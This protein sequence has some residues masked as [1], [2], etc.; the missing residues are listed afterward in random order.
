MKHILF[1]LFILF[2]TLM[3]A[4]NQH[5]LSEW[6]KVHALMEGGLP[7]S[8]E[9]MILEIYA[10]AKANGNDIQ[11]MKAEI[12]LMTSGFQ[13]D[14]NAFKQAIKQAETKSESAKFPESAIWKSIAAQL[15]WSYYEQNRWQILGRTSVDPS[16][17]MP[18]FETWDAT[19][20]SEKATSLYLSSISRE[21]DLQTITIEPYQDLLTPSIH[22]EKLR[23]TL[24][25]LLAF[26]AIHFFENEEKDVS[27]P[28]FAFTQN[29]KAA[30]SDVQTFTKHHFQTNDSASL[31]W[32]TIQLYRRILSFH[33]KDNS[34]DALLDANLARLQFVYNKSTIPTKKKLYMAALA[35]VVSQYNHHPL[36]ALASYRLIMIDYDEDNLNNP[37]QTSSSHSINYKSVKQRLDSIVKQF[38]NS[39]GGVLAKN[40]LQNIVFK[41][42]DLSTEKVVLPDEPSK[43]L[44]QYRN[45]EK[46]S[47]R[48][49]KLVHSNYRFLD[50]FNSYENNLTSS[51]LALPTLKTWEEVLPSSNDFATH[52]T[53][54][55]VAALPVG[56]YAVIVSAKDGFSLTDNIVSYAVFQVSQL[57]VL[58]MDNKG[59]VLDRKLGKPFVKADIDFFRQR[60]NDNIRDNELIFSTSVQSQSEGMF[61]FPQA[62]NGILS[63]RIRKGSDSLWFFDSPNYWN[64][65]AQ[66]Q[67]SQTRTFLFTDRAIYR[68]G[69]T[70]YFKGII[71]KSNKGGRQNQVVPKQ[72]TTIRFDDVNGQKIASMD[73]T[74]NEFGS[75]SG[76][77]V[78]P[79]NRLTGNMRIA[80]ENGSVD[81]SVEEYKRPKFKVDFDSIHSSY[82]IGENISVVGNTLAYAGNAV[83]NATVHYR[84]VRQAR[85]PFW[86]YCY[87]FGFP[88]SPE[89]E[90]A[91]GTLKTEN[92]GKFRIEFP[93]LADESV[94]SASLPIFSYEISAD[95]TDINGETRSGSTIVNAGYH[96]LQIHIQAPDKANPDQLDTIKVLT[97]NL[98]DQFVSTAIQLRILR[99]KSPNG[100]LRN[101]LWPAPDQFLMDSVSF[102]NFFPHDPYRNEDDAKTWAVENSVFDQSFNSSAEGIVLIP[103]NIWKNSGW[104]VIEVTLKDKSGK[105]LVEKK[106]VQVFKNDSQTLPTDALIA[107][108]SDKEILPGNQSKVSLFTGCTDQH[109]IQFVK[110]WDSKT[111]SSLKLN[112]SKPVQIKMDVNE[113]DR[114]GIYVSYVAVYENRMYQQGAFISVPWSNKDLSISWET[115]RDKLLPGSKEQWTMTIRGDQKEKVSAE[116]VATLYDASLDAF[117][118]LKWNMMGLFPTLYSSEKWSGS[119]FGISNGRIISNF[120]SPN[121]NDF[122]KIYSD[123]Y[124][125]NIQLGFSPYAANGVMMKRG[126]VTLAA[127]SESN[128]SDKSVAAV[129]EQQAKPM[130]PAKPE[131]IISIRKNL[132]ETAFFFPQLTTDAD[133]N[134]QLNFTMPE[135]LT[136]WRFMAF[137]HTPDLRLGMLEGMVR[138]QK[139][140]MVV[141]NLPRFLR[142]GDDVNIVA[143]ISSLSTQIQNGVAQ[144]EVLN[145]V[146]LQPLNTMFRIKN[147]ST[148]FLIEQ[149]ESKA[150][151]WKLHVP[152]SLY[153]PVVIRIV[154]KAGSFSDGEE[155]TIPVVTNRILVTESLP[156]W[157]NGDGKKNFHFDKLINAQSNTL[158]NH[159]LTLEYAGNPIWYAVQALPYL[160]EYP[161][162]CAEQTF[163][164]YYANALGAFI[165]S[166]TPKLKLVF[167]SWKGDSTFLQSPLEKNQELKGALLEET[168]WV[169]QAQSESEQR[170]QI[171]R[172]F[173]SYKLSKEL[174]AS[175]QKLKEMQLPSGAFPW[176]KG[177]QSDRF[178]TQ[179]IVTGIGRLAKLGISNSDLKQIANKALVFLDNEVNK[180]YAE[181]LKRKADLQMQ[182]I[183]NFEV[184]YLYMRSFFGKPTGNDIVAFNYYQGQAEKYF[185]KFN[186][187]LKGMIA[188]VLSRNNLKAQAGLV[189]QS[190]KETSTSNE[191]MGT[192][193][194]H[195]GSSYWWYDAPVE[196]QALLIEC[197]KEVNQ[198]TLMVDG[199]K[200]WLLKNKQTNSWKTSKATADAIYA[201]LLNDQ[202]ALNAEPEVVVHLGNKE[203]K[204]IEQNQQKGSGYFKWKFAGKEVSSS[205]GNISLQVTG[206]QRNPSWG[207]VYW[208]YFEDMDKVSSAKTPL[209][210]DKKIFVESMTE[211]GLQLNEVS[212]SQPLQVGNKV[213]VRIV[214]SVDRDMEYVQLKDMRASCFE[215]INVL[216]GF[217][218]KHGLGYYES[219][220]D[221]ATN[222][223]FNFLP[224]GKYVFE[225]PLRVQQSG[226]FSAGI[227]SIQC[228]YAPEF[229]S[230]SEGQRVI[231]K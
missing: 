27:R 80:N 44:L 193:W 212:L 41:H 217:Q 152:E 206:S 29:D 161:Y 173:E 82:A 132:Q 121:I 93:A 230:H 144:I 228:M 124:L 109:V 102:K 200:R 94:P 225:Y 53:E 115:H 227:A 88:S 198:D 6:K 146:T 219:T 195:P 185:S 218:W 166:H 164:R 1:S 47:F 3:F 169:L 35:D 229:S 112:S 224:K 26:R 129:P 165:L 179:Y 22:T 186:P 108:S 14:E 162:E 136:K 13:R 106:F 170:K 33:L 54:V 197:F 187:Y 11:Q 100:I 71:V 207:A 62:D 174:S 163:N 130:L 128:M 65:D 226:D 40:A 215:P 157:M 92:D 23:P 20:F 7:K 103:S 140:L 38:P 34:P 55:K 221:L 137:A 86:W 60:Y 19:R 74:S 97:Q 160:M 78:T 110:H 125:P 149:N 83:D 95:V 98:N 37:R 222:F 126:G 139:E 175:A 12:F 16:L 158:V 151:S 190:L 189:L 142:Q 79:Q 122:V 171:S 8:A 135:A 39:E 36:S 116:M 210:L 81:F 91:S 21:K 96:S 90:I 107:I 154:A 56:M 10:K 216:S 73:M 17:S 138:T 202:S 231:V 118:P 150:V 183:G 84:V 141:P 191:E 51:L 68:P 113:Q 188:L 153:V 76:S 147:E 159:S 223:F 205:D 127:M 49:V 30:F 167:E 77:F 2:P 156:L 32:H 120:K 50:N 105:D 209:Q 72:K 101:R 199:M 155:N 148:T 145:A 99:L 203:L 15:F 24:F 31:L 184:Q 85:F 69:Q 4:Q 57:S 25:D 42:L 18:D 143:K 208:Q 46:V 177:M 192:Y 172:L 168:P 89:Q 9:K 181:L 180:S 104:Y 220:K 214:L 28:S 43:I 61:N 66:H 178:I 176:F 123:L 59:F 52:S 182:H 114:G 117:R 133:G 58:Q 201:L 211:K 87:R 111:F 119:A 48:L 70:V 75:F 134:I 204:G 67:S 196:T 45:V 63:V 194:L 64:D 5:Y 131:S 213:V